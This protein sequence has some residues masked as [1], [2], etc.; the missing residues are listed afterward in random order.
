MNVTGSPRLAW[1]VTYIRRGR[2]VGPLPQY[3]DDD[4][5]ALDPTDPRKV[6]A[7]VVAA[8]CWAAELDPAFIREQLEDEFAIRRQL[9]SHHDEREWQEATS[10][11]V[12]I[13]TARR[14]A[15]WESRERRKA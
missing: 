3:G 7:C 11:V 15:P 1:A 6:A 5:C 14:R 9:E 4:W 2:E 12:K 13:S 10:N 8:E